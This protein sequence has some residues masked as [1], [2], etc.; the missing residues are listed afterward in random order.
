MGNNA[1][2]GCLGQGFA[3]GTSF[4]F[5]ENMQAGEPGKFMRSL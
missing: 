5:I 1:K 3:A 2:V 4:R